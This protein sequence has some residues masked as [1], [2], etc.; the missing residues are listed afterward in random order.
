[1]KIIDPFDHYL[2]AYSNFINRNLVGRYLNYSMLERQVRT[3]SADYKVRLEGT[4]VQDLPILPINLG[5]GPIRILAW[6]QMHGNETTTTKA[7]FDLF[8]FF[9]SE[10]EMAGFAEIF[11]SFSI[12]VIPMLNPDGAEKYTR[13]NGNNVDLNRDA[14]ALSQKE[15]QVLRTVIENFKPDF[16][17]NL[18]DQRTIF[19]AGKVPSAATLSFL[20]PAMDEVR[21]INSSRTIAMQIIAAINIR[22]KDVIPGHIGRFEDSFNINCTG[23]RFM[24]FGIPTILLEAGHFPGD[25][26][27][28][29]TRKY[30]GAAIVAALH[31][32]RKGIYKTFDVAAYEMIPE[33]EKC[34]FDIILRNALNNGELVDIALQYKETLSAGK[35]IFEPRVQ[36]INNDLDFFAH[37]NIDCEGQNVSNV[38]GK[39]LA[40]NDVVNHILLNTAI[41]TLNIE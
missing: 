4:S 21:S 27:R 24:A 6:S 23:D 36:L 28:E 22:L 26:E 25:Y 10:K 39:P 8:N 13:E 7:L 30:M 1:M 19:S 31:T 9:S 5:N 37:R 40:E 3:L 15:S 41:I 33:N 18:H 2:N 12:K 35:I 29:E 11:T 38:T 20:A 14:D 17:L 32:I 16:C 34:F